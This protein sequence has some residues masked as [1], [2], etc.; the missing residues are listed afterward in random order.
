MLTPIAATKAFKLSAKPT[1][2]IPSAVFAQPEKPGSGKKPRAA[3]R[4]PAPSKAIAVETFETHVVMDSGKTRQ[5][6]LIEDMMNCITYAVENVKAE[7]MNEVVVEQSLLLSLE[8]AFNGR[9]CVLGGK[10]GKDHG[11]R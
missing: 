1:F 11:C 9:V 10:A 4:K 5:A 3:K 2:T 6:W 8:F 7:D